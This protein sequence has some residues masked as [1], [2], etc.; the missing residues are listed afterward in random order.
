MVL[1]LIGTPSWA[2]SKDHARAVLAIRSAIAGAYASEAQGKRPD[3]WY[4]P[5]FR[6]LLARCLQLGHA[7]D[8]SRRADLHPQWQCFDDGGDIIPGQ[9]YDA[10]VA[11]RTQ[12]SAIAWIGPGTVEATV[13]L[14]EHPGPISRKNP[15]VHVILRLVRFPTGW[16]IDDIIWPKV[17]LENY[18]QTDAGPPNEYSPIIHAGRLSWRENLTSAI[19]A[20]QHEIGKAGK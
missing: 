17:R 1:A 16:R 7:V 11:A 13:T 4:S 12:S 6:Q 8:R 9:D 5:Q 15:E 14:Q 19:R 18:G 20:M 10:T 2:T 3:R